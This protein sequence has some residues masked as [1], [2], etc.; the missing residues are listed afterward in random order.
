MKFISNTHITRRC[1]TAFSGLLLGLAV[2]LVADAKPVEHTLTETNIDW[3]SAGVAGTGNPGSGTITITGIGGN[4]VSKAFLYWHGIG[5]PSYSNATVM[6][7]GNPVTGVNIGDSTTNC[8]GSGSSTAYRADVTSFVQDDGSY[9][10]TGLSSGA[11]G[12]SSNGA[13]LV[14]IFDDGNP[15]NNRDLAFFEGN[16]SDTTGFPGETNGWH[17]IL[18]PINYGGGTVGIEFHAADGQ[19]AGDGPVQLDTSTVPALVIADDATLWDGISLPSSGNGRNGHGLWDIHRF[20][21]TA[22]FPAAAQVVSLGIDGQ[23]S[24]GDCLGLVLALVDLEPFSAPPPQQAI[25]L[26]P[27]DA[28]NCTTDPHTVTATVQDDQMLPVST[29]VNF[30]VISGPNA[31]DSASVATDSVGQAQFTYT[32]SIAGTDVIEGCFTDNQQVEQ[33]DSVHKTWEVCNQPPDCTQASPTQSCLW[34]PNHMHE[35]IGLTGITDPDGDPVTIM[36]TG[37]TSDE[38][39]TTEKGSGGMQHSPDVI[40]DHIALPEQAAVRAERSGNNDGRVYELHFTADDGNMGQCTGTVNVQVPHHLDKKV[41]N[42]V[43]SGQNF[44]ATTAN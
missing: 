18:T 10:I 6:I 25:N 14:V 8:W 5:N 42:A 39:T 1:C 33:C 17:T 4:P 7:D 2:S 13:S 31:G 35:N 27:K 21:M 38:A 11:S 24:G 44:D 16:D 36:F 43:D 12:N 41:C 30:T 9:S 15:A 28:T 34:P 23:D 29:T 19:N 3:T 32:S 37:A 40:I 26:T 20:D 22:A